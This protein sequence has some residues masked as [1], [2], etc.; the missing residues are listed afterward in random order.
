MK[1]SERNKPCPCGS[2]VKVKKCPNHEPTELIVEAGE[3]KGRWEVEN[4]RP[5]RGQLNYAMVAGIL[6]MGLPTYRGR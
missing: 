2:G 5:R 6:G 1:G 3:A 4:P